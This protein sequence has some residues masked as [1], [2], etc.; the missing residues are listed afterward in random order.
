MQMM[1]VGV[2]LVAALAVVAACG[3]APA[4]AAPSASP[5]ATAAAQVPEA[6]RSRSSLPS[7][8]AEN[9]TSQN[10]PWNETA[11]ACFWAAYQKGQLAEFTS[12]RLTTEGDPITTIY[13][14]LGPGRVE[15]FEDTTQ[16][17]FGV[18]GWTRLDCATLAALQTIG[19]LT[20]F[21]PDDSCTAT[22]VG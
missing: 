9:A 13:R 4:T 16:D 1:R 18:P 21:G 2:L 22:T 15:I 8:G 5:A 14:V 10:G 20:D 7:C 12:T 6:V 11:R 3:Q 17:K 19:T